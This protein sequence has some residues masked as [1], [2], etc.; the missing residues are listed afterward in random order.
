MTRWL[1]CVVISKIFLILLSYSN[2]Q[3]ITRK[4]M[5]ELTD[6]AQ[7]SGGFT[8][9]LIND[10]KQLIHEDLE[11]EIY[12][13]TREP[14]AAEHKALVKKLNAHITEFR[15]RGDLSSNYLMQFKILSIGFVRTSR[16]KGEQT[17]WRDFFHRMI[18]VLETLEANLL[19]MGQLTRPLPCSEIPEITLPPSTLSC[20][21]SKLPPFSSNP[22]LISPAPAG[23]YIPCRLDLPAGRHL[24]LSSSTAALE[25]AT[26]Q[27]PHPRSVLAFIKNRAQ[28]EEGHASALAGA[29][30][31]EIEAEADAAPDFTVLRQ[32]RAR[33]ELQQSLH[34]ELFVLPEYSIEIKEQASDHSWRVSWVKEDSHDFSLQPGQIE[35]VEFGSK[36][37]VGLSRHPGERESFEDAHLAYWF[38]A[39]HNPLAEIG[40]HD[41]GVLGVLDGHGGRG[42]VDYAPEIIPITLGHF[43]K[44]LSADEISNPDI[45]RQTLENAFSSESE[46]F[47]APMHD[48]F[49]RVSVDEAIQAHCN[50][51]PDPAQRM[52]CLTSGASATIAV[53][54][55]QYIYLVQ[56]GDTRA[57]LLPTSGRAKRLTSEHYPEDP[58][59]AQAIV[60]RGG[61]VS[62]ETDVSV[63]RLDGLLSTSRALGD[64]FIK[65]TSSNVLHVGRIPE[66][67]YIDLETEPMKAL[68]LVTNG[69]THSIP[70]DLRLGDLVGESLDSGVALAARGLQAHAIASGSND[71]SIALILKP[72]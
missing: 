47:R 30:V 58:I 9:S 32:N 35:P 39:D 43:L 54:L 24:D 59:E 28:T 18:E 21:S 19:T 15:D 67:T 45:V 10:I 12:Q 23:S 51:S 57:T 5:R 33:A 40:V 20:M 41:F 13:G 70:S 48:G 16:Y 42:I 66:V 8:E 72:L 7:E 14:Y 56:L 37:S 50:Y 71:D 68:I 31:L 3:A 44:E 69:I 60:K 34:E 17:Y 46:H 26:L 22:I 53:F 2:A 38:P 65:G 1:K 55:N 62:A 64:W 6:R 52:A 29:S 36:Y 11:C 4:Q 63:P 61:F 49:F 25:L 27:N